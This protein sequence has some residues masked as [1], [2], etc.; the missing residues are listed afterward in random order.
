MYMY[1]VSSFY[2]DRHDTTRPTYILILTVRV[3]VVLACY[4]HPITGQAL[5][6]VVGALIEIPTMLALIKTAE[7]FRRRLYQGTLDKK[8]RAVR[9]TGCLGVY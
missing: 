3:V 1:C 7:Y 9:G 5:M 2:T 8:V 4:H 6:S